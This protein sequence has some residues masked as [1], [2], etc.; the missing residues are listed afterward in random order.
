MTFIKVDE[1]E[2]NDW[3]R[4]RHRDVVVSAAVL[5]IEYRPRALILQVETDGGK[6]L[7]VSFEYGA[8]IEICH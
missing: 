5:D 2:I 3:V 8:P 7:S 6:A 4:V 1:V